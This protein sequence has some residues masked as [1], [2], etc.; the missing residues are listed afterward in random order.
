[1][2]PWDYRYQNQIVEIFPCKK[3]RTW[4]LD[5]E[6]SRHMLGDNF[7]FTFFKEKNVEHV[8]FRHDIKEKENV[9]IILDIPLL[10][11]MFY[12][13]MVQCITYLALANYTIRVINLSLNP[14]II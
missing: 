2:D 9:S 1:M 4:Y 5:D 6:Y 7:K 14:Y 3:I 13:L 12:S 8:T 10:L 11:S